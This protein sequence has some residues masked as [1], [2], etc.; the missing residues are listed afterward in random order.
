[1]AF[2][3]SVDGSHNE[4]QLMSVFVIQSVK[5]TADLY[6]YILHCVPKKRPPFYF[7][8]NS[9][10]NLTDCNDFWCVKSWENLTSIAYTFANLTCIL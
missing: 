4:T 10:K 2:H 3:S 5:Q 6:I 8:N 7:S 9:V 1:M